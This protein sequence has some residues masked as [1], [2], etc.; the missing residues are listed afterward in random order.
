VTCCNS[1]GALTAGQTIAVV[2]NDSLIL[3][4]KLNKSGEARDFYGSRG[5]ETSAAISKPETIG[6][7][8]G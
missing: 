6:N 7:L 4:L 8:L 2:V 1:N 3:L 5:G